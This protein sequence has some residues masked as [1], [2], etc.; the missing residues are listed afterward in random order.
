MIA[1]EPN[2]AESKIVPVDFPMPPINVPP[3]SG[4]RD[5]WL[6][7]FPV[8]AGLLMAGGVWFTLWEIRRL[9]VMSHSRN[10]FA[11]ADGSVAQHA[12]SSTSSKSRPTGQHI[13]THSP[14]NGNG[15]GVANHDDEPE[16]HHDD[17][18]TFES[19]WLAR[20]LEGEDEAA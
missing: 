15:A 18:R 4:A 17:Y 8:A 20:W 1:P 6:I 10:A 2:R 3:P 19:S 11:I 16:F 5:L 7:I 12:P 14:S 13:L 9:T